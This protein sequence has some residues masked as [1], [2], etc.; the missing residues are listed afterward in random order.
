MYIRVVLTAMVVLLVINLAMQF[1]PAAVA[2]APAHELIMLKGNVTADYVTQRI[3]NR[4][5]IGYSCITEESGRCFVF[6]R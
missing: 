5:V 1:R 2:A 3:G 6:L 4:Q